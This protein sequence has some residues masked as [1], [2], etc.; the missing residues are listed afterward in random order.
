MPKISRWTPSH[1]DSA[2]PPWFQMWDMSNTSNSFTFCNAVNL[3]AAAAANVVNLFCF[4]SPGQ[5]PV[6]PRSYSCSPEPEVRLG[7]GGC[8]SF[9]RREKQTGEQGW[10]RSCDSSYICLPK[11]RSSMWSCSEQDGTHKEGGSVCG[12]PAVTHFAFYQTFI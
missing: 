8:W 10:R 4:G 1:E 2:N 6:G 3:A 12:L 11:A 5:R 9:E 7:V